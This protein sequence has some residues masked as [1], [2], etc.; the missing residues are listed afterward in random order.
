[1]DGATLNTPVG[2]LRIFADSSALCRIAFPGEAGLSADPAPAGHPLLGQAKAQLM[3]YFAG[4]RR[5]FDLPLTPQGTAFQQAVW[6]MMRQIP[7]G[8]TSTYGAIA[9]ELGHPNKA[10]AVGGAAGK[11]P[12]PIVI[13]CHRVVGSS[14]RLTG[15]SGG[16]EIKQFLLALEAGC[17]QNLTCQQ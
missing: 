11:N 16:L 5:H 4:K 15:F 1:M 13:P 17:P 6:A 14:G 8:A 12:L 7:Y 2:M 9:A 3:E 10:R